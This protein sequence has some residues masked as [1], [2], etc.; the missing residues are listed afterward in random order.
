ML[1]GMMQAC[2]S[3]A[4]LIPQQLAVMTCVAQSPSQSAVLSGTA[5]AALSLIATREIHTLQLATSAAL[6]VQRRNGH[7]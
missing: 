7:Y 6:A 4:G 3:W 1:H 2:I 5:S